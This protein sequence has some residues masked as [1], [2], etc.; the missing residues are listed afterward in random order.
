[1]H[2]RSRRTSWGSVH[3]ADL[4][5]LL[6][7]SLRTI[8]KKSSA[9]TP[10]KKTQRGKTLLGVKMAKKIK[11]SII[12]SYCK[13]LNSSTYEQALKPQQNTR[14]EAGNQGHAPKAQD[15]GVREREVKP[16]GEGVK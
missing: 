5:D 3:D 16:G 13:S 10:K 6:D 8:R 11:L 7:K 1:M 14:Q 2:G 12:R 9:P 15:R 4:P